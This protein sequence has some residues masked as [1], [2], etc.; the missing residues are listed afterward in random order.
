MFLFLMS[1]RQLHLIETNDLTNGKRVIVEEEIQHVYLLSYTPYVLTLIGA[2][3][4]LWK[5][6]DIILSEKA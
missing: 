5:D 4:S 3:R 1:T 2:V 6:E